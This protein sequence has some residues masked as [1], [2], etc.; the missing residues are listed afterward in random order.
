MGITV[1]V[2]CGYFS[3]NVTLVIQTKAKITSQQFIEDVINE[4]VLSENYELFYKSVNE[5]GVISVAFD[6]NKANLLV[7]NTL[8]KLRKISTDFNEKGSFD[9]SIPASYLFIPSS[10]FFSDLKLNVDTSSLLSYD[11][12]LITGVKEYG[13]NSSLVNLSLAV[14]ISYQV[15]VPLMID[16]VDNYI[17]IPIAIEI[18]NGKVPDVILSM[19]ENSS[20]EE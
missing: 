10:F 5:D 3:D 1:V 15:I 13:I 19:K 2:F 4:E 14:N 6:V 17:E 20:F 12:K 7:S 16:V 9:V 11:V 8:S 18:I